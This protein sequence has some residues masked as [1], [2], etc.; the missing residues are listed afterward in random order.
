MKVAKVT[1]IFKKE[2][3]TDPGNYRPISLLSTINKILEKV[4]YKRVMSFLNK[5]KILYKYQFGF[6]EKHSTIQAVIEIT[7]NIISE[8]EK[9]N[10]IAGIYLDLSKDFDTVDHNILLH[11]LSHYGIRGLPLEWFRSYL[12]KRQQYTVV[13]D[14]RSELKEIEF[15]VPQGSVLG[16]LLFL[17]YVNDISAATGDNKLRLFADDSNVFVSS[18]DPGSLKT[19]MITVILKMCE[20]FNANK[21]TINMKKTAYTIFTNT[22]VPGSLNNITINN[23]KVGRVKSVK[24]LGM[25]LDEKL[26][27]NE[28]TDKL[29][30]K[31]TKTNQAFKIVKNFVS[32]KQKSAL[33]YAYFHSALQYGIEVYSQG[34]PKNIKK[35]TG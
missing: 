31:L 21:L 19:K 27:W 8:L 25:T 34:T 6:R 17:I 32:N 20:W 18:R 10:I 9:K 35:I 4:M 5:F 29:L 15:G 30:T 12:E 22:K 13:N 24:Y 26:N 23:V 16:P 11:K 3:K 1:P 14:V 2:D 33:Y 7:D 28:H